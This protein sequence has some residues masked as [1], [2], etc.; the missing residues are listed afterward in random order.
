MDSAGA[1]TGKYILLGKVAKPHGIRGEIKIYP[2]SGQPENFYDYHEVF[3]LRDTGCDLIAYNVEKCRVQGKFVLLK[4][5]GCSARKDAELLVGSEIWLRRRDLPELG[6]AEYYWLEL[7]GKQ[8]IT[9]DG[10]LLGKI[11]GIYGTGAHDIISVTGH[12]REYLIPIH[13]EFIVRLDKSEVIL[14]LPPGLL[15]ING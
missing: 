15:D 12:G 13:E 14:K 6:G 8:A 3:L 2:Y 1:D 10:R 7:E 4:L 9:E 5:T 11:T